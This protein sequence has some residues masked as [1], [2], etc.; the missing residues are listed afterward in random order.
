MPFEVEVIL[1]G[2]HSGL[3][4]ESDEADIDLE[5]RGTLGVCV[6]PPPGN[7]RV[8]HTLFRR[9]DDEG[10][11]IDFLETFPIEVGRNVDIHPGEILR[12]GGHLK[13]DDDF[14]KDDDFGDRGITFDH[15]YFKDKDQGVRH[16][17][18]YP[19]LAGQQVFVFYRL[20]KIRD[21]GVQ[22]DQ[23]KPDT[24]QALGR[25]GVDFSVEEPALRSWLADPVHTPYPAIAEALLRL[26]RT[27]V[28]PV[29]LDVIV[30]NYEH[31]PGV[32]SPRNVADVR[33]DVL[34][35]AISEG[36][37]VRYG[38]AVKDFVQILKP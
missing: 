17:I 30:W 37:N 1:E 9:A 38:Q 32:S 35:A 8:C 26:G 15:D 10:V 14:S 25:M 34:K 11:K 16:Q 21:L 36:Y 20:R 13:E 22:P 18:E 5:V 12:I 29:F 27:L 6:G 3:Q 7:N 19:N 33:D 4:T 2:I 23:P 24:I 31:T 28:A